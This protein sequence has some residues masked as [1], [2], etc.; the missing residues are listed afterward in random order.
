MKTH[1]RRKSFPWNGSRWSFHFSSSAEEGR[2]DR[3]TQR[4]K[5]K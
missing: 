2:S 5:E 4:K 1:A 3:S